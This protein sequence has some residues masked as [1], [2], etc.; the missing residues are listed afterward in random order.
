MLRAHVNV[1]ED[2]ASQPLARPAHAEGGRRWIVLG[3]VLIATF[4][5]IGGVS[6]MTLA[7]PSLQRALHASA[8][9]TEL[10]IAA[11]SLVYAAFLTTGGR[12]GDIFGRRHMMVVGLIVFT[13][14]VTAG[15]L[16]PSVGVLIAARLVQGLGAAMIYPQILSV[17]EETFDGAE[18]RM[19]LGLFGATI[20]IALASGQLIGGL[21]IQL[22]LAGLA[23]RS[24]MLVLVPVGLLALAGCA[25]VMSNTRAAHAVHLDL[26]G[27]ALLA[28]AL[29]LLILPLLEGRSAGWPPW[30]LAML[31]AAVPA[32]GLFGWY[33]RRVAAQGRTPLLS[34]ALLR[35]RAFIAG[36]AI[37]IVYFTSV[38]GFA[39]YTS[40]TLQT[41]L[42]FTP[43]DAGL[44]FAPSGVGL[45][46]TSLAA[47]RLVPRLG[48]HILSLGYVIIA[49]GLAAVVLSV[50][51]A[52]TLSV[53]TLAPALL[54]VGAGQG[55][56]MSSLIGSVLSGVRPEDTGSAAG[57][58]TTSFQVGQTLGIAVVGSVY[59]ALAAGPGSLAGKYR[60]GYTGS[61]VLLI[62][63]AVVLCGLVFLLPRS[64]RATRSNVFLERSPSRLAGLAHSFYFATG[65]RGGEQVMRHILR[66]H[67]TLAPAPA[68]TTSP[69]RPADAE[70]VTPDQALS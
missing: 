39:L 34:L 16:A 12:L 25:T 2:A 21:L 57:A 52:G 31:G 69:S 55:L 8:G 53:W 15:G 37:G 11:Y 66:H 62:A 27:T 13:L 47:P 10:V 29:V 26:G 35:Q 23:W 58:L 30:M 46:L 9:Q 61:V 50:H 22:D 32:F 60:S 68:S 63:L 3:I 7:V 54:I 1:S 41:G 33:E 43:L 56:S 40:I 19:A 49:V 64:E 67:L 42:H 51:R 14:A 65:G 24:A 5:V 6:V 59:F 36:L 38:L 28:G 70:V 45:F 20:G 44:A 17:I 48:R 4:L 18:R